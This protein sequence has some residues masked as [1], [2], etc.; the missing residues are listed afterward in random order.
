MI[1]TG[2]FALILFDRAPQESCK[3]KGSRGAIRLDGFR[4]RTENKLTILNNLL[5]NINNINKLL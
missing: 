2:S 1:T 3:A 4:V 5:Y